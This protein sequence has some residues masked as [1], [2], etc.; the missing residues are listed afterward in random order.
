MVACWLSWL[1][2]VFA[3]AR[4]VVVSAGSYRVRAIMS[5]PMANASFDWSGGG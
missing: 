1:A 3:A 5:A 2:V 4:L